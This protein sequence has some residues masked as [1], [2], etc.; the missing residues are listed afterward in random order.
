MTNPVGYLIKRK[1]GLEGVRGTFYDYVLAENGVFI[2]TEGPLLAARVPVAPG[3]IRGLASLKPLVVLRYGAIPHHIF[4]LA[5]N[6]MMTDTSKEKYVAIIWDDGYHIQVPQQAANRKELI[7]GADEGHGSGAG[8]SYL[9]PDKVI[10]DLHSHGR[11]T[12]WFS[13]TD[14]M[15]DLGLKLYGVV[16][17]LKELPQLQLRVG[18]Y[19]Y[20]HPLQWTDVFDGSPEGLVDEGFDE[21]TEEEINMSLDGAPFINECMSRATLRR[22]PRLLRRFS[23]FFRG[24]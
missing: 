8:V 2:E 13:S 23:P 12:A 10:L 9:N 4:E 24:H 15:D 20:F 17:K 7:D 1:D 3:K 22:R 18:V 21:P 5:L 19:G 11:M 16:G 6:T 14:N